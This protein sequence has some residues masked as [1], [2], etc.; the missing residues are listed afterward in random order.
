M[1]FV[2][3]EEYLFVRDMYIS[4]DDFSVQGERKFII[5]VLS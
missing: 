3:L 2:L 4:E 5:Y 1:G